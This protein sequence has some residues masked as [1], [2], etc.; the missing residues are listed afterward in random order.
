MSSTERSVK[1]NPCG[2]KVRKAQTEVMIH[3]RMMSI[4][5]ILLQH[6]IL[7]PRD[8]MRMDLIGDSDPFCNLS[9][10]CQ[11]WQSKVNLEEEKNK[12]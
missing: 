5:L 2:G 4:D 8:L 1:D 3:K 11:R 7:P 12:D 6:L 10:G 9:V